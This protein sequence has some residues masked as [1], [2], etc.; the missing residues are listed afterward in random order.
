MQRQDDVL[1]LP[2][3][4]S[5]NLIDI[6]ATLP[7]FIGE[8]LVPFFIGMIDINSTNIL[9]PRVIIYPSH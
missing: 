7:L 3:F 6:A 2:A 5:N 4:S 8:V 1:I 9:F